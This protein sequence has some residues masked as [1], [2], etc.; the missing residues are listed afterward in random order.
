MEKQHSYEFGSFRID[1]GERCLLHQETPIQLTPRAF[2]T[3][4]VLVRQNGHIVEKDELLREVWRGSF[5]EEAIVAQNVF[6]IRKV[7]GQHSGSQFIETVPKRGYRFVADVR[8]I[9]KENT[10]VRLEHHTESRIVIDEEERQGYQPYE[11]PHPTAIPSGRRLLKGDLRFTI[12]VLLSISIIAGFLFW[13]A[14]ARWGTN[15]NTAVRSVA[16]LPFRPL[17][18][19]DNNDLLGVGMADAIIGRFSGLKELSV[20]PTSSIFKY[21]DHDSDAVAVGRELGVDAVLTGTV[22]RAGDRVRVSVQLVSLS[23]GKTLWSDRFDERFIDIFALQDSI[24]EQ[25]AEALRFDISDAKHQRPSLHPRTTAAYESYLMGLYFWNKRSKEGLAKAVEYFQDATVKDSNYAQAFA[26]LAD[27]YCLLAYYGYS[28]QPTSELFEKAKRA[29]QRSIEL[30][31]ASSAQAETAMAMVHCDYEKDK[32]RAE[33]SY[34]R[35][36]ELNPSYATAHQR[37]AWFL[38]FGGRLDDALQ[39]MR[40]A[41]QLDPLSGII[42]AALGSILNYSRQYDEAIRY[43]NR[44]L[45]LEPNSDLAHLGLGDTYVQKG[46]YTEAIAEFQKARNINDNQGTASASL[47]HALALAGEAGAAEKTLQD[48]RGRTKQE[49]ISHYGVA[50]TLSALGHRD[51]ALRELDSA[52]AQRSVEMVQIRFDPMLDPLRADPRFNEILKAHNLAP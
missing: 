2:D 24:S 27:T 14:T 17:G 16:V 47:G 30:D 35:A 45:E 36:L 1:V 31:G 41:Q 38:I 26:G 37:Y 32:V 40:K 15:S 3:L 25:I 51:Q 46:M 4:L 48:L 21:A 34:K 22:Q 10:E 8:E 50:L 9:Q 12:L 39:Q 52:I 11:A 42:N 20:I 6:A 5:V 44:A 7:L 19:G 18:G 43:Y 23:D 28:S 33:Q 49:N 29:A 13:T